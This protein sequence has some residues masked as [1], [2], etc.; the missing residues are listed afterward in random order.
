M[1]QGFY[2]VTKDKQAD[3]RASEFSPCAFLSSW[4]VGAHSQK[5]FW[6][7]MIL[8]MTA[9]AGADCTELW[10]V[11]AALQGQH[12][13]CDQN[14]VMESCSHCS[15]KGEQGED[16]NKLLMED[17]LQVTLLGASSFWESQSN[18]SM[19]PKECAA[20]HKSTRLQNKSFFLTSSTKIT[21]SNGNNFIILTVKR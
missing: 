7:S 18:C 5:S 1:L 6:L 20:E 17:F 2:T 8:E 9:Q 14:C 4:P 15:H 13:S 11:R 12:Q 3:T 10:E 19:E 21:T 16:T